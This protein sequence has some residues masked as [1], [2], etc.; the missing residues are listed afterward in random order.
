M[1]L[2]NRL[3][4]LSLS[5]FFSF[6]FVTAEKCKSDCFSKRNL[7][8]TVLIS[9]VFMWSWTNQPR[10]FHIGLFCR[11]VLHLGGWFRMRKGGERILFALQPAFSFFLYSHGLVL[12]VCVSVLCLD[13]IEEVWGGVP[14]ARMFSGI[15][16]QPMD[17]GL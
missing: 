1:Q 13:Q 12:H 6:S 14:N 10:P 2:S 7:T 11:E 17:F 5:L 9:S 16:A 4:S 3:I 15:H 8:Y